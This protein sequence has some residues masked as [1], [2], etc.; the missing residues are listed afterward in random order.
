MP[1]DIFVIS[2]ALLF[3]LAAAIA[4]PVLFSR[5]VAA[6]AERAVPPLGVITSVDGARLHWV[7][8]GEGQPLILVHGL[9]T[10]M[11]SL[12]F[13]LLDDLARDFHVL[14]ID[15]PGSGWSSRR[16]DGRVG[17]RA[18]AE[19]LAAFIR[20]RGL[21]Q[22]LVVGHS[23][24][25]AVGLA[26]AVHHPDLLGGLALVAPL[27]TLVEDP[28]GVF[29]ALEVHSALLRRLIAETV[30]VP[31][32]LLRE[33]TVLREIFAPEDVPETF[34]IEGGGVLARRPTAYVTASADLVAVPDHLP[35]VEAGYRELRLP[36]EI[37][38]GDDDRILDPDVHGRPMADR[39]PGATVRVVEGGHM[40]PFMQPGLVSEFV[41]NVARRLP[42]G[43]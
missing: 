7:E 5:F 4:A 41:R 27:T 15:R 20:D 11:R 10:Q 37:L 42:E 31:A 40:L 23:L 1:T 2:L 39:V 12:T 35:E 14:A 24:G 25:G 32:T 17:L 28:P 30:A 36:V 38:Y 22:P 13:P 6:Q 34:A 43:E 9:G 3:G 8:R 18:D 16:D 21:E 19:T 29:S 26:T 33:R